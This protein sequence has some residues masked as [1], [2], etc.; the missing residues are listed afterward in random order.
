MADDDNPFAHLGGAKKTTAADDDNPFAYLTAPSGV[1]TTVKDV[2][3]QIPSGLV[4]GLEAVPAFPAQA[5]DLA[6]RVTGSKVTEPTAAGWEQYIRSFI[7]GLTREAPARPLRD[8]VEE[9]R[10]GG[11]AQYLPEAETS[12]GKFAR[13]A[14]E[15]VPSVVLGGARA[16]APGQ[17]ITQFAMREAPGAARRAGAG[18]TAGAVS[19]AGGQ[20]FEG[21]PYEAPAR[22]VGGLVGGAVA[23][24]L[25]E[26]AAARAAVPTRQQTEAAGARGFDQF[27]QSGFGLSPEAS[28]TFARTTQVELQGRGLTDITADQTHRALTRLT[29]DPATTPQQLQ[30]AYQELGAIARGAKDANERLAANVAQER[31][32]NFMENPPNWVVTGGDPAAATAAFREA[33][34]NWAAAKRAENVERRVVKAELKAGATHSGLNLEN[35]LRQRIGVL[36]EPETRGGFTPAEQAAFARFARGG[37]IENQLRYVG[38]I[39]GGGGGMGANVA[40]TGGLL[41]LGFLTGDPYTAAATGAGA[42]VGGRALRSLGNRLALN[43]ARELE[44]MLLSRSPLAAAT[45]RNMPPRAL[46]LAVLPPTLATLGE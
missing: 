1:S 22:L 14:S 46:P 6:S 13:T 18:A 33:N 16:V 25:A 20:I 38:N 3:K 27:R 21:T 7:P 5:V 8:I 11:I 31:L 39:L 10:G 44:Q 19:E 40:G 4:T 36:A 35:Q 41:G 28:P 26:R 15:F 9:Q 12:A 30:A 43:R 34:A 45:P 37:P 2:V 24:P 29:T 42:L 32:L 23:V 17:T